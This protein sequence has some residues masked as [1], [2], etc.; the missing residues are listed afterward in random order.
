MPDGDFVAKFDDE[1][2]LDAHQPA[3]GTQADNGA[4]LEQIRVTNPAQ[5]VTITA[6]DGAGGTGGA[7]NLD[8]LGGTTASSKRSIDM[9][10]ASKNLTIVGGGKLVERNN[11]ANSHYWAITGSGDLTVSTARFVLEQNLNLYIETDTGRTVTI[12]SNSEELSG[13]A[14]AADVFLS[15]D[16]LLV[17]NGTAGWTGQTK[18]G[19]GST[20]QLGVSQALNTKSRLNMGDGT[21]KTGGYDNDFGVLDVNGVAVID[22]QSFDHIQNWVR[23]CKGLEKAGTDFDYGARLTEICLLGNVAKRVNGLIRWDAENMRITNNEKANQY[24]NTGYREG[25]S[26]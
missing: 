8:R 26:L 17:L 15:G 24:I 14:S 13:G 25:W 5:D 12:N 7:I 3:I 20:I 21:L 9:S 1:F 19:A 11:D 10:A 23:V 18:I 22:L 16:G 4:V 2:I 6:D